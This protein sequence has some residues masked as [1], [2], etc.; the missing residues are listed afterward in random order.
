MTRALGLARVGLISRLSEALDSRLH[1][2][3]FLHPGA[4]WD[5]CV[6]TSQHRERERER[7]RE[8]GKIQIETVCE[9]DS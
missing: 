3:A 1:C 6:K 5:V 9:I 7:E 2:T 8:K 4:N